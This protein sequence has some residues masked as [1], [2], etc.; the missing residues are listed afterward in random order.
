MSDTTDW[1]L[2]NQENWLRNAKLRRTEYT[3]YREGWDHDHCEFCGSKFCLDDEGCLKEGYCTLESY[4]WIC[5][6]CFSDFQERFNFQVEN[7]T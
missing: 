6:P 3:L 2:R 5:V 7:E 4:H 1:R